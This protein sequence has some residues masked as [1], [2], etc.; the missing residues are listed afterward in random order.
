MTTAAKLREA[1]LH[2]A[3]EATKAEPTNVEYRLHSFIA[4]L[5]G[6]MEAMG[7]RDLDETL[8]GLLQAPAALA[9]PAAAGG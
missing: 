8:W 6:T 3:S 4:R 5:S 2:C 1:M 9:Q 7:E